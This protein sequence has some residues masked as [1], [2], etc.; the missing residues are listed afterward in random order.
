[1]QQTPKVTMVW[2]TC[3]RRVT[4][5]VSLELY[6]NRLSRSY[7]PLDVEASSN[8]YFRYGH[9]G[10]ESPATSLPRQSREGPIHL[11]MLNQ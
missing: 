9:L 11:A 7:H 8:H 5:P 10:H 1:M 2:Y 4:V 3:R 6:Y